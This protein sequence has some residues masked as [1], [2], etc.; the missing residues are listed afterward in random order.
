MKITDI[1]VTAICVPLSSIYDGATYAVSERRTIITEVITDEGISG[2]VYTGDIRD[3]QSEVVGIIENDIKP[4]IIGEDPL[5]VERC[6]QKMFQAT[7][8][9][10]NR[11]LKCSAI[12]AV[13]NALWDLLGKAC[14]IPAY[15]L[16]GGYTNKVRPIVIGGYY[17]DGKTL[18]MLC[19][20][21]LEYKAQGYAGSKVKVGKLSP[22][23]DAKRIETIRK[24]AGDDFII[25]ADA[26][27]GYSRFQAT[28]FA[29][30]V[31][32][33]NVEWFEEPVEWPDYIPGMRYVREHSGIAVTAG[34]SDHFHDACRSMIEQRAV[35]IINHDISG[36]CGISD[37]LKVAKMA[38]MYEIKM[39]HHEDPHLSMHMLAGI[40]LGL[41]PEYF[42]EE[43][44]PV[45]PRI[46]VNQPK[47]E[48]GW[49][50]LPEKPGFGCEFDEDFV[51]KYTV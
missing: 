51:R 4:L 1:K 21:M 17:A 15:K 27:Q 16:F 47:A 6:W 50:V 26:N 38:D 23:E 49:I 41:Y 36:G 37:W 28:E 13:D 3:Q 10:F 31:R 39:A 8:P 7:K 33:L 46:L 25:T 40:R 22:L 20:E 44:D 45:T 43:R 32:D 30:A 42:S 34:Q 29:L 24:A 11:A 2:R 19:D 5:C 9:L 35:D 48:N 18:E 12:A 14:N